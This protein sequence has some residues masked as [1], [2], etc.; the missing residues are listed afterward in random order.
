MPIVDETIPHPHKDTPT[1]KRLAFVSPLDPALFSSVDSFA[2]ALLQGK[3]DARYTP[4]E[5][6]KW[7]DDLAEE[8]ERQLELAQAEL[9]A[10][11]NP[12]FRRA[13][14]DI[15]VQIELGHFFAQKLRA[16]VAYALYE[17]T[18]ESGYLHD[19]I[20]SYRAA[21]AAWAA[22]VEHTIHVYMADLTFGPEAR[23]RG[24][25]ADRLAAIDHDLLA[26]ENVWQE[27]TRKGVLT[28][29]LAHDYNALAVRSQERP[30]CEHK[31]PE[32]FQAGSPL[33]LE[34][35]LRVATE[36]P[37]VNIRVH[38]RRVNQA[39]A[40]LSQKMQ[41]E[42]QTFKVVILE[43]VTQPPYPF[44]YFFELYTDNGDA[45]FFPGL[46]SSLTNQPYFCVPQR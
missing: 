28:E 25:W 34:I 37:N 5:V 10:S 40:F 15:T 16:G 29:P 27:A 45:W 1:P 8:A 18:R 26:M 46:N 23:K 19:A 30:L 44:M 6:A 2:E 33:P 38:Y 17:R 14:V 7:L 24:H 13:A 41:R 9:S 32:V 42:G 22:I 43:E 11:E 12:G 21:R 3:T 36:A 35:S 4:L 31:Q 39:E 20:V